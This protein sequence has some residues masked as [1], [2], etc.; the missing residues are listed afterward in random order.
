M[1]EISNLKVK[2]IPSNYITVNRKCSKC[3]HEHSYSI[4]S[5]YK[6]RDKK[7]PKCNYQDLR[8]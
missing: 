3:S 6:W 1:K 4:P 2:R 7:C 5:G 8:K